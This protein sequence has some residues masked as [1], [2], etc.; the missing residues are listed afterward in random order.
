MLAFRKIS[1]MMLASFFFALSC[2]ASDNESVHSNAPPGVSN[3]FMACVRNSKLETIAA[4]ACMSA[5]KK[6][7][8]CKTQ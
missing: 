6:I 8:R 5:E 2:N 4:A 7:S 1:L 3:D